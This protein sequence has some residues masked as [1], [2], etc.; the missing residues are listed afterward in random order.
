MNTQDLIL[1]D[2]EHLLELIR[3]RAREYD[4]RRYLLGIARPDDYD[5]ETHERAFRKLKIQLGTQLEAEWP[6]RVVDFERPEVRFEIRAK[7]EVHVVAI[8][9]PL[10]IGGR[11]LKFSREIPACRWKCTRCWGRGCKDCDGTGNVHGPSIQELIQPAALE[12]TGGT[13]TFF[14]GAGREDVDARMLGTGRPF[15]LEIREPRR[16]FP[17][18]AELERHMNEGAGERARVERLAFAG[19]KQMVAA[20]ACAAEKSYQAE[21]EFESE[22][23]ADLAE[24]LAVLDGADIEQLSPT[25]V[26][27]RR[28]E[29]ALRIKQVIRQEILELEGQRMRWEVRAASGTYIKEL[30]SGDDGRTRPSIAELAGVPC[31]CTALDVTGIHWTPGWES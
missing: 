19:R 16:R 6:E 7:R 13:E 31:R 30:I 23:P 17:D 9:S 4:F 18:L 21:V 1:Q 5:R 8:A 28:G 12:I 26:M 22:P 11:Y 24:R 25:R 15:V 2:P 14:H 29:K 10:F 3:E 27:R 20:K